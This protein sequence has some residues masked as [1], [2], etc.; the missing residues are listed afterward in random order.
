MHTFIYSIVMWIYVFTFTFFHYFFNVY[1]FV[2]FT[3]NSLLYQTDTKIL[4]TNMEVNLKKV[5]KQILVIKHP[6]LYIKK[7]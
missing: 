3:V 2:T 5:L 1:F 6:N 7:F 4:N